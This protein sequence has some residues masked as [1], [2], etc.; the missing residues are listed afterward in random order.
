MTGG[1]DGSGK[2]LDS[3]E[4]LDDVADA[5]FRAL[6]ATM[7]SRRADHQVVPLPSGQVLVIGGE[8]DPGDGSGDVILQAVDVFEPGA[9]TFT[10][11]PPLATPRDDHRA[12]RLRDGRV[13]V[14]GGENTTSTASIA[15]AETYDAK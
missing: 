12:V 2:S 5:S 4:I 8:D 7:A 11:L 15:D 10:A 9:E 1:Q 6:V 14:T 3:A 13:L